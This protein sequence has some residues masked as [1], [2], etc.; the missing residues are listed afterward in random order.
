M[1][2]PELPAAHVEA[3]YDLPMGMLTK[4]PIEIKGTRLGL[5]PFDDLLIE[6][7]ARHDVFF[8]CFPFDTDLMVGFVGLVLFHA[9]RLQ[10]APKTALVGVLLQTFV[11]L[12]PI[13]GFI[14]WYFAGPR[15]RKT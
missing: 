12:L 9:F 10:Q 13:V 3:F 8:L 6:R 11:I 14:I 4:I 5:N 2:A 1:F 15:S 7:H